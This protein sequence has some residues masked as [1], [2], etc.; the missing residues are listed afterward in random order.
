MTRRP[1]GVKAIL[2]ALSAALALSLSACG[3]DDSTPSATDD[4]AVLSL[5]ALDGRVFASVR[6][7][8]HRLIDGT[9]IRLGFSGAE[10]SAEAGCN[11]L[12][13][14]AALDGNTLTV[15]E[16][17][18]TEMGC[19]DGRNDQDAWLMGFL[20]A[21]ATAVLAGGTL[22]LTGNDVVI[23]LEEQDVPDRSG[24]DPDQPTSN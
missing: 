19:P 5:E 3:D 17:G 22:T 8:G 20:G 2:L 12:F 23:E 16:M 4:P 11:H 15:T 14:T 21:G 6:V 7:E 18:G 9:G 10:L 13:G 24:G 1:I